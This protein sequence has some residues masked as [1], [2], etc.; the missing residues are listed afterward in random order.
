MAGLLAGIEKY[1]PGILR[2]RSSSPKFQVHDP[3]LLSAQYHKNFK[4]VRSDPEKWGRC[5]ESAI[6]AHLLNRSLEAGYLEPTRGMSAFQRQFHP[7]KVLLV[8]DHGIPWQ[9]FLKLDPKEL[10]NG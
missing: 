5:V 1:S 7:H 4:E 10:F 3:S 9:D 2:Q 6:G 8:G